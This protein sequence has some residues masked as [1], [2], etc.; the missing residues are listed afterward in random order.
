MLSWSQ[1]QHGFQ[2]GLEG[3]QLAVREPKVRR[4]FGKALVTLVVTM[5][6]LHFLARVLIHV[7]LFLLR[8]ANTTVASFATYDSEGVHQWLLDAEASVNWALQTLPLTG[9]L[10][11]RSLYSK[12]FDAMFMTMVQT[13]SA[14]YYQAL[15]NWPHRAPFWTVLKHHFLRTW[16]RMKLAAVMLV[17]V[18]LPMVGPYVPWLANFKLMTDVLGPGLAGSVTVLAMA[19][20]GVKDLAWPLFKAILA[21]QQLNRELLDPFFTR[22]RLTPKDRRA[23]FRERQSLLLGFVSGFYMLIQIPMIGPA[24]FVFAQ[25]AMGYWVIHTTSLDALARNLSRRKPQ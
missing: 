8:G 6:I 11:V 7:P 3:G 21:C 25:A 20:P 14:E 4:W 17:L 13:Q 1:I 15:V 2:L 22:L 5:V 16:R 18:S 23:W 24:F 19:V 10:L 9:V 12:P